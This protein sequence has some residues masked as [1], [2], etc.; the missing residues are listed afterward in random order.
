[1]DK[2]TEEGIENLEA[3]FT[4]A[5]ISTVPEGVR[6]FVD[7]IGDSEDTATHVRRTDRNE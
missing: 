4:A 3:T 2:K 6:D 1:M 5:D 7:I